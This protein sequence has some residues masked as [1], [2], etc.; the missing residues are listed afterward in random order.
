M[1]RKR[2]LFPYSQLYHLQSAQS[3][4]QSNLLDRVLF[5]SEIPRMER[6]DGCPEVSTSH[7]EAPADDLSKTDSNTLRYQ[8]HEGMTRP[9][10]S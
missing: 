10:L 6:S 2:L 3:L 1:K 8:S 4:L 9:R 7:P 5:H